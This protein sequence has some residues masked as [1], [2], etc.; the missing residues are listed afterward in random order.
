MTLRVAVVGLGRM[1]HFYAQTI[2]G[3]APLVHLAAVADPDPAARASLGDTPASL[4]ADPREALD[5][6]GIDAVII[7]TPTSTHASLVAA[8]ARAGEAIFCEKPLALSV[9]ETRAVL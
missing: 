3:L 9:A 7:A 1:G 6:P 4:L 5:Q 2:A 8:A